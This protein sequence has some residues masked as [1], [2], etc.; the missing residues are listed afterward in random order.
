VGQFRVFVQATGYVP[1]AVQARSST[2]YDEGTGSMAA[3]S[4]VDWQN[5]HAGERAGANLPVIHVSWN[6]AKAYADWLA[7]ETGKSYRL[8][9]EAEFEY[10]LRAGSSSRYP[11]GDGGP[12]TL[13][14]NI[15]GDGDRSASRRNWVNS[16]PDY[17]D[18]H[19]G[20]APVRSYEANRFGIHDM[21]GNVS[22]WVDDC[23]HDSYTRAPAD[24]SAWVNPGCSRRVIRGASWASAPDQVRSAFRLNASPA[25][26]NP[27]LGFRIARDL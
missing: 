11:W 27:R 16:F 26:T 8:P 15:T 14:G 3:K 6:D 23:W 13:V 1:S 17:S 20:P 22:E 4:G 12:T 19:W 18:G 10:V 7:A 24:G 25:T 9:S 21:N 2:I 5:D